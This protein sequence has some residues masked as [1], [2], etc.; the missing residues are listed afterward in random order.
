MLGSTLGDTTVL[1]KEGHTVLVISEDASHSRATD[2]QEH[3]CLSHSCILPD[4]SSLCPLFVLASFLFRH[5]LLYGRAA[6][7]VSGFTS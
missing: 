4:L 2:L 5:L 7:V 6:C 1:W 3:F